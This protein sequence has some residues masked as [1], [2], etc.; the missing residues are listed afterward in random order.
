MSGQIEVR[1]RGRPR[2]YDVDV[3]TAAALDVLW[4]KGYEGT[5]IEDLLA[6]TGLALS[7]LYAAFGSKR[8]MMEAALARYSRDRVAQLAPLEHGT[9]GLDDIHA[10]LAGLRAGLA[11]PGGRGCFMVNSSAGAAAYDGQIAVLVTRYRERIRTGLAAALRRAIEAG[12]I[13]AGPADPDERARVLQAA[14]FGAQLAARSGATQDATATLT[15]LE[16]LLDT[17]RR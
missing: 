1:R 17:W 16:H 2:A 15:A 5:T 4:V 6:A 11:D 3:A 7:S 13:D 9:R 10:F 14:L 8:G 12:E